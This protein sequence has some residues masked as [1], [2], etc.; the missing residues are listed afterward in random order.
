M[1]WFASIDWTRLRCMEPPFVPSLEG[2]TDSS[3]FGSDPSERANADPSVDLS[4]Q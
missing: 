4:S 2:E 3:Y 1:A